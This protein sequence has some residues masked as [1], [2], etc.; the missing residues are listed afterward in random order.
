MTSS[1]K[2]RFCLLAASLF[3]PPEGEAIADFQSKEVL[4]HLDRYVRMWGGDKHLPLGLTQPAES[5]DFLSVLQGEY[6]RLFGDWDGEVSL[7]EST[8]KP[9]TADRKCGM[10]F[11][12]SKGLI[13]GDPA[14]HMLQLYRE[15]SLE[16]PHEY[17]SMP[18]HLSLELDFLALLYRWAGH[19]QIGRFIADHMD[20]IPEFK[21]AVEKA[22]PHPFYRSAVELLHLFFQHETGR[23]KVED[24][25]QKEIH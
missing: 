24:H 9:W 11:A 17:R 19:E 8:Y 12:A 14:L 4:S 15:C 21:E 6:R 5:Q 18:D 22:E 10:V 23:S 25:G 2:E 16:I 3:A 1:E 20:W 7:V 13:M